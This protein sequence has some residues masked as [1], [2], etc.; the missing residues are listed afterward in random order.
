MSQLLFLVHRDE[1]EISLINRISNVHPP[2]PPL[3]QDDSNVEYC[4][5]SKMPEKYDTAK[6]GKPI[7]Y[8]SHMIN[9][10]LGEVYEFLATDD[11][12][13][14]IFCIDVIHIW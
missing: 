8:C 3:I 11:E 1:A 13:K 10:K 9:L 12:C 2:V 4:N 7:A 6:D 5:A 14:L